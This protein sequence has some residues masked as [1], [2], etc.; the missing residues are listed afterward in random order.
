VAAV[1]VTVSAQVACTVGAPAM[2]DAVAAST[3]VEP[4]SVAR[5]DS[6]PECTTARESITA[7]VRADKITA[8]CAS[9]SWV[10]ENGVEIDTTPATAPSN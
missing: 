4:L 7:Y 9:E 1:V 6:L 2:N 5:A 8:R 10:D 3:V